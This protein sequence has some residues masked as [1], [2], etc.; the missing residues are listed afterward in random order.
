MVLLE[1]A[2]FKG[3][4]VSC[5]QELGQIWIWQV[6]HRRC[7]DLH[8]LC[9]PSENDNVHRTQQGGPQSEFLYS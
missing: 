9:L 3:V 1:V 2:Y 8:P 7:A 5:C 4:K 6:L